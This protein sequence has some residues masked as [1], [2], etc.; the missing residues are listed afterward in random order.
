M[1]LQKLIRNS[2]S[3]SLYQSKAK[4]NLNINIK[5]IAF[6]SRRVRDKFL[7]VAIPGFK[8]DGHKYIAESIK[9]GAKVVLVDKSKLKKVFKDIRSD[10]NKNTIFLQS[11]NTRL[12]LSELSHAFYGF[13]SSKLKV[14]GITGTNGKTT[15]SYLVEAILKKAGFHT[16]VLGTI[17][18]RTDKISIPADNTTPE[19]LKLH[20]YFSKMQREGISH[21]VLEVSSHSLDQN[22]TSGIR[23]DNAIFTNLTQDHLDYHRTMKDY[24]KA[25]AQLFTKLDN[26]ATAI[27]NSD[28]KYGKL[29]LKKTKA[30][31]LTYGHKRNA[32][33]RA[34]DV[35]YDK[36]GLIF[37]VNSPLGEIGV[38]SR[39]IGMH[40]LYN[41]LAA[42]SLGISYGIDLPAIAEAVCE[43]CGVPGRLERVGENLPFE[44]FVDYAHTDDALRNVLSS[45]RKIF[46]KRIIVV[47]G[48][49]GDR[50]KKKRPKMGRVVENLADWAVV[51]SD[52]PRNEDA[53]KIISDILKGMKKQ[54]HD[55]ELDRFKAIER[56][57]SMARDGDVVLIAGKGHEAYQIFKDTIVPFDDKEVAMKICEANCSQLCMV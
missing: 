31:I 23:F 27:I 38:K 36:N 56:A 44:I 34:L 7:F 54:N 39:L 16:G 5:G 53:K 15:T 24:F 22:R 51:T 32:D 29:L 17:N 28:D 47:F 52:N 33:I 35:K 10:L 57:I 55:I 42:I 11:N 37:R 4:H 30:N 21:V 18:Y 25:K 2:T 13:N 40:N 50:D 20:S 48:C 3:I 49:G 19:P 26:F 6:D 43:A 8:N 12:A 9:R 45:L 46:N 1:K 14:T 41:I